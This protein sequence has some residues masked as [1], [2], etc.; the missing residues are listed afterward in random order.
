MGESGR[1]FLTP[2]RPLGPTRRAQVVD[3]TPVRRQQVPG[4]RFVRCRRQRGW[5]GGLTTGCTPADGGKLRRFYP[6]V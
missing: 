1:P 6:S 3:A 2:P 5:D 4:H